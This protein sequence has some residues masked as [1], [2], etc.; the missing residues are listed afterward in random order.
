MEK[1]LNVI[2]SWWWLLRQHV[3]CRPAGFPEHTMI[4]RSLGPQH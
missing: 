1:R 2:T 3:Y 4:A